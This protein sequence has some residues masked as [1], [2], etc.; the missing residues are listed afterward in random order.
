[1]PTKTLA[2]AKKALYLAR[3]EYKFMTFNEVVA[4]SNAGEIY[5]LSTIYKGASGNERIGNAIKPTGVSG[6]LIIRL[7][8]TTDTSII[9]LILFRG[10]NEDGELPSVPSVLDPFGPNFVIASKN[11]DYK[12]DTKFVYDKSYVLNRGQNISRQIDYRFK[13]D[14][15]INYKSDNNQIMN[16]G[17]Y[18]LVVADQGPTSQPSISFSMRTTFI[19]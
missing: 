7:N 19:E 14:G 4:V 15:H 6:R 12:Y 3:P 9:R 11:E 17:L 2:I 8:A 13:L 5:N 10:K 16:G 1:M 18:L